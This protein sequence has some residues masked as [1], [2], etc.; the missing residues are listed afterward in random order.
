MAL[1]ADPQV[2]GAIR[3]DAGNT[4]MRLDIALVRLPRAKVALNNDVRFGKAGI[5]IAMTEF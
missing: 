4:G 3:A 5:D 2:A 1:R